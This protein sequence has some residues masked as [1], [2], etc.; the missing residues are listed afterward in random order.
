M[1]PDPTLSLAKGSASLAAF[2]DPI[3]VDPRPALLTEVVD[4]YRAAAPDLVEPNLAAL[5]AAARGD[6]DPLAAPNLPS[7]TVLATDRAVDAATARFRPASRLAALVE[8]GVCEL[9]ALETTQPNTALGGRED[10]CVLVEAETGGRA[11]DESEAGKRERDG[12]ARRWCRV[13]GDP[14][15]RDRYAS[16]VDEATAHRLRT[17]SRHR[18]YGAF[19]ERCGEALAADVVRVLD[20]RPESSE[21]AGADPLD[22]GGARVRAYAVGARRSALDGALRRACE[23][24]GIGSRATFTRIKRELREAELVDTEAVPQRI[25]RPRE[26]LVARG[27]LADAD[28]PEAIVA[29]VRGAIE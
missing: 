19:R 16:L 24:A 6:G 9:L 3:L 5:R 26:R 7:L 8:A 28:G 25:G 13:G 23:D 21:V 14:T 29:A 22:L 17:P 11:G 18:A 15:L 2:S 20:A 10:G 27:A 4:A 12:T 1:P